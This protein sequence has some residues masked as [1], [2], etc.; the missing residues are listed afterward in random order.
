RSPGSARARAAAH[1]A[2]PVDRYRRRARSR[3]EVIRR[4]GLNQASAAGVDTPWASPRKAQLAPPSV[5][6][7]R[8]R[9]VDAYQVDPEAYMPLGYPGT[10][11][12]VKLAPASADTDRPLFVATRTLPLPST[13]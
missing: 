6:M 8:P 7:A 3:I 5:E 13:A 11:T 2:W 9:E 1:G 10:V 4:Q 12:L